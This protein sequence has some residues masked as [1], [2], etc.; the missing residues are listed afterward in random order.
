MGEPVYPQE[1][2]DEQDAIFPDGS[3][4]NKPRDQKPPYVFVW[5]T[6]GNF[7][8]KILIFEHCISVPCIL[9]DMMSFVVIAIAKCIL[10]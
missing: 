3:P 9:V 10:K 6:C 7:T 1:S 8:A 2:L 4:P 5:K